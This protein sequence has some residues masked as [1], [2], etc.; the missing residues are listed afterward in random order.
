MEFE[1]RLGGLWI[2]QLIAERRAVATLRSPDPSLN[3]ALVQ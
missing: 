1:I 2:L 3:F